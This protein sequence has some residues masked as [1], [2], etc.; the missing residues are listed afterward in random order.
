MGSAAPRPPHSVRETRVVSRAVIQYFTSA[1][2]KNEPRQ[3]M[4]RTLPAQGPP[5]AEFFPDRPGIPA[6]LGPLQVN[7]LTSE[8]R[9]WQRSPQNC[10]VAESANTRCTYWNRAAEDGITSHRETPTHQLFQTI[11]QPASDW[12][13]TSQDPSKTPQQSFRQILNIAAPVNGSVSLN[14]KK[15]LR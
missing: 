1:L 3:P 6:N 12:Q 4:H 10:F 5:F 8:R 14:H 13:F 15:T 9:P 11:D 2:S 7:T